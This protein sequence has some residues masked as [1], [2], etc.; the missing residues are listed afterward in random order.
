MPERHV[1]SGVA[2]GT[3]MTASASS[4]EV[5]TS[6]LSASAVSISA[7]SRRSMSGL[8]EEL[9][10][11]TKNVTYLD[12]GAPTELIARSS[13]PCAHR[14]WTGSQMQLRRHPLFSSANP[15]LLLPGDAGRG[16]HPTGHG[17]GHGVS[18][19]PGTRRERMSSAEG[20]RRDTIHRGRGLR[21]SPPGLNPT[22]NRQRRGS[23]RAPH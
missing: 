4:G 2:V 23:R 18:R 6:P 9:A 21:R 20:C 15:C 8:P 1:G 22:A 5:W 19:D 14:V 16:A 3:T 12:G 7:L 10:G 17:H 13:T 11:N